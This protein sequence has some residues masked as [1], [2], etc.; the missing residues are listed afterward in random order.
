MLTGEPPFV[1]DSATMVKHMHLHARRP[2]PSEKA[3]VGAA[4]DRVVVTAMSTQPER[5]YSGAREFLAA[6]RIAVE[7]RSSSGLASRSGAEERRGLALYAEARVAAGAVEDDA[8]AAWADVESLLEAAGDYLRPR[9]FLT[10]LQT[11]NSA[12][13]ARLLADEP[14][15]ELAER[16][17]AVGAALALGRL[18]AGRAGRDPRVHLNLCVH[19]GRLLVAGDKVRGG[20]LMRLASWVPDADLDGVVGS[21]TAFEGLAL[22]TDPIEGLDPLVRVRG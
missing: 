15:A 7:E 6:L 14:S 1:D 17:D 18:L 9:G 13:Y 8:G 3:N 16:R 22:A 2:R 4:L 11:G 5:R 19:V 20:A 21:P 10:A 12:L